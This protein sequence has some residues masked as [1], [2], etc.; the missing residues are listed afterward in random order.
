MYTGVAPP[1]HGELG[2][3]LHEAVELHLLQHEDH[4]HLRLA[5]HRGA[6][7]FGVEH[8]GKAEVVPPTV[9]SVGEEVLRLDLHRAAEHS[10][11]WVLDEIRRSGCGLSTN[12]PEHK[13][14]GVVPPV[15][16]PKRAGN[17]ASDVSLHVPQRLAHCSTTR[18]FSSA[19][20]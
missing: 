20:L 18:A 8:L 12:L 9:Q 4:A 14:V 6:P 10:G 1:S 16:E 17:I 15:R 13:F 11:A 5:T 3:L 7:L 19:T 2:E